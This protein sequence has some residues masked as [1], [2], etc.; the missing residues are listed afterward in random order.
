MK[1]AVLILFLIGISYFLPAQK[2]SK[3]DF[4]SIKKT[5][6]ADTNLYNKLVERLVKLDSTL[7]EDDYYLIYYGQV[8]SKKYDPYNGGEEIEKFNE[9]YGAGKYAD[10]S[11]IGEKILKQNPVNLTLLY[12]TANC[13][14]ETGNVLMKRRYNR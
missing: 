12:R 13:F 4:D 9:E 6:S 10:A 5:F 3:V 1:K 8:F 7:T 2:F 11:L 14:R